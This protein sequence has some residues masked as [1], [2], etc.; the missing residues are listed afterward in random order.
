MSETFFSLVEKK[1]V[2]RSSQWVSPAMV[3]R[4]RLV[5][6]AQRCNRLPVHF[7]SWQCWVGLRSELSESQ[8]F[9]TKV[10]TSILCWSDFMFTFNGAFRCLKYHIMLYYWVCL[11]SS[12]QNKRIMCGL[13]PHTFASIGDRKWKRH[14]THNT[15]Q[16]LCLGTWLRHYWAATSG[17]NSATTVGTD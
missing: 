11:R 10:E 17:H 14:P 7:L 9:Q 1:K 13:C 12:N 5:T 6:T 16:F 4:L 3:T 15:H 8:F 2:N